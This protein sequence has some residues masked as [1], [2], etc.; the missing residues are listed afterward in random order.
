MRTLMSLRIILFFLLLSLTPVFLGGIA[1]A[2][3]SFANDPVAGSRPDRVLVLHSY[4]HGYSRTDGIG[5][6]IS[7][8]FSQSGRNVQEM[9]EYLDA[10]RLGS[11][12]QYPAFLAGKRES[13][14]AMLAAAPPAL[15]L[16]TDK[17]A[18]E[19]WVENRNQLA[20]SS[21]VIFCGV[22][23]AVP[24]QLQEQARVTGVIERPMF[25]D[26]VVAAI[27]LVPKARK[28]LVLGGKTL[29]FDVVKTMLESDLAS[30]SSKIAVGYFPDIEIAS[31]EQRLTGL[32][33]EWIVLAVGRPRVK[34]RLLTG[35]EAAERVTKASPV[36]VFVTWNSW[37]GHGPVGGSIIVPEEQGA[38]AA[39]MALEVLHGGNSGVM[40]PE[41]LARGR[42]IFDYPAL[43]RFGLEESRLPPGSLVINKQASF[44]ESN[45]Q[46]VW[47]YSVVI[48]F[49]VMVSCVLAFYSATLHRLKNQLGAQVNFVQSLMEAMPTPVFFKDV[50]GVYQGCNRAFESFIAISR[51]RLVGH[52]VHELFPAREADVFKKQ[53]D[54]LFFSGPIQIYEF[55]KSTPAGPRQIR[56][57]KA[58]YYDGAG[59]VAG[60]VGVVADFTDLYNAERELKKNR[61][62]LEAIFDASPSAIFCVDENGIITHANARAREI[63]GEC[64]LADL[65]SA[66]PRMPQL[67]DDVR[68]SIVEKRVFAVPRRIFV[69]DGASKA[70]DVVIYPLQ[71]VGLREAVVRI[72]DVTEQHRM[73]ELLVQT[74]K[75]MSVGGLAAGMAHEINN[76]LGGIMQS[77]QVIHSRLSPDMP[78]NL[79][80][81]KT[82]GC[83]MECIQAYLRDREI[84]NL[85]DGLRVS[86]KRAAAIVANMLEFSKRTTSAWLPVEVNTLVEKSVDL[87]LQDYNLTEN[88][89]FKRIAIVREYSPDNPSV[90]CSPQQ[91][92]QVVF[93][94]LRNAAQAMAQAGTPNPT[95]TLRT[96][97]ND[98]WITLEVEDNGPGMDENTRRKVFEPFFTTKA[99]GKG[100]GL[101]LSIIYFIV[102]ENHGG[103]IR[104]E[105]ELGKGA[106]FVVKLPLRAKKPL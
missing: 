79:A 28:L 34:G 61:K 24:K 89:D 90:P 78:A 33:P 48:L 41:V 4:H 40:P 6:G 25:T 14:K 75:M 95:I 23:D 15:V 104:V 103:E 52:T 80:S 8:V 2:D 92:Q 27:G 17:Q 36:P 67:L 29:G 87:I 26:T 93:N 37:S 100:T 98:E 47:V 18:M 57:H 82:A 39:K 97:M 96:C 64:S 21:P 55:E 49:L 50:R 16:L 35:Q 31:I 102:H 32:G 22:R 54:A 101:G 38:M 70:E 71:S 60:L 69:E 53:D 56:F 86:A 83:A 5:A 81:A 91:I 11:T 74:E 1:L 9:V 94:L 88:Y 106:K 72:D 63:C 45:K 73:Q 13:L 58:L 66:L 99:P 10:F 44:Y 42:F 76:P 7:Q 85:L 3:A 12:P 20:P 77:A 19:F 43:V 46:L 30:L 65:Q 84:P 62:Y 59:R 68:R 105:S 51:D